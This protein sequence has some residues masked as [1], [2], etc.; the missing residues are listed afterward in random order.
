MTLQNQFSNLQQK[1]PRDSLPQRDSYD[2]GR[3]RW[4][5]ELW[6]MPIW[7]VAHEDLGHHLSLAMILLRLHEHPMISVLWVNFQL[8]SRYFKRLWKNH[9]VKFLGHVPANTELVLKAKLSTNP[10]VLMD[11]EYNEL[12][13]VPI[14]QPSTVTKWT[15]NQQ[16]MSITSIS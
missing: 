3:V 15:C 1:L 4:G 16:R 10:M 13:L 7:T 5:L 8:K 2:K 11:R 12:F 14:H 9:V 6:P